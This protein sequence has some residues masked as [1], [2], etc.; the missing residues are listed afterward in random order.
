MNSIWDKPKKEYWELTQAQKDYIDMQSKRQKARYATAQQEK[1]RKE[2]S[3]YKT[4]MLIKAEKIANGT[5]YHD[6]VAVI[7]WVKDTPHSLAIQ[8]TRWKNAK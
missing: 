1:R 6:S 4:R 2:R 5:V 7:H 3:D 8:F